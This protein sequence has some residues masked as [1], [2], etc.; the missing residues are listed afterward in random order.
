MPYQPWK[1]HPISAPF[2]NYL[3]YIYAKLWS[4]VWGCKALSILYCD[5]Q[6]C[7]ARLCPCGLQLRAAKLYPCGLQLCAAKL[8]PCGLQLCAA[9]LCPCGLQL[10]AA[11]LCPCGLQLFAANL[12]PWW[13]CELP[14][15]FCIKTF[16][17]SALT[18]DW[19]ELTASYHEINFVSSPKYWASDQR[20]SRWWLQLPTV[21]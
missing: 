12:C 14:L 7:A 5:L 4:Y 18:A 11:K 17:P 8:C 21:T 1:K 20:G 2:N 10:C 15:L 3:T 6:L 19:N 13:R 16:F 9:K